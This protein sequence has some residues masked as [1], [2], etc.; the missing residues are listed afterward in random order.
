MAL[1]DYSTSVEK[2][3]ALKCAMI[4]PSLANIVEYGGSL[5]T[6]E[7]VFIVY[8]TDFTIDGIN[9]LTEH[10]AD[11]IRIDSGHTV[12]GYTAYEPIIYIKDSDIVY[13]N[14]ITTY[15]DRLSYIFS[16]PQ[17][18]SS[19]G[20]TVGEN[21]LLIFSVFELYI[22]KG[23]LLRMWDTPSHYIPIPSG[24]IIS[25]ST[26]GIAYINAPSDW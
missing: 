23:G 18:F 26:S 11:H 21:G 4:D 13:T 15:Q 2:I 16:T 17:I 12:S 14:P 7:T 8:T 10:G 25:D 19:S 22:N 24:E 3:A 1:A 9:M 6:T 20:F 5:V